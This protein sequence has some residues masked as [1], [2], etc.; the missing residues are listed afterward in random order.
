MTASKDDSYQRMQDVEHGTPA[1]AKLLEDE[2]VT[3]DGNSGEN[4]ELL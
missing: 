3:V 2:G 1:S 4:S